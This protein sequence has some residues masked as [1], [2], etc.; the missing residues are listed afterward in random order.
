MVLSRLRMEVG[1]FPRVDWHLIEAKNVL[2]T[3]GDKL[4]DERARYYWGKYYHL[5][6]KNTWRGHY[7]Q[8]AYEKLSDGIEFFE[9]KIKKGVAD[10]T[11]VKYLCKLHEAQAHLV[12]EALLFDWAESSLEEAESLYEK[13]DQLFT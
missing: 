3:Q 2:T 6:G 5:Q 4:K 11:N 1:E 9:G 7:F 8:G 12:C 10:R 13:Y